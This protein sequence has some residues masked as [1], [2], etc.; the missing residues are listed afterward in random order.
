MAYMTFRRLA[1]HPISEWLTNWANGNEEAAQN[2]AQSLLPLMARAAREAIRA[3]PSGAEGWSMRDL[4]QEV[5]L[6]V[7]PSARNRYANREAFYA[8]VMKQMRFVLIDRYRH[9]I[10]EAQ[11]PLLSPGQNLDESQRQR[12]L[13]AQQALRQLLLRNERAGRALLMRELMELSLADIGAE[14]DVSLATVK[15]DIEFARARL[16]QLMQSD[17]PN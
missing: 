7:S 1:E 8:A 2:I 6:R 12:H 10:T 17:E 15:R 13:D 11:H 4:V 16:K 3:N 9:A 5:W 14:L